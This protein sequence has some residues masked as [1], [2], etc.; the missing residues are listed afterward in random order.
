MSKRIALIR[1]GT[2]K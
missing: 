2:A 1:N